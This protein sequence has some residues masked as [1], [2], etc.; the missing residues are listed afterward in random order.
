MAEPGD[1]DSASSGDE[2]PTSDE[3]E[4]E[5]WKDA[6]TD[7]VARGGLR[8]RQWIAEHKRHKSPMNRQ[9][10]HLQTTP[11][12]ALGCAW[13]VGIA[14]AVF[15]KAWES[16]PSAATVR[17]A[18]G[19]SPADTVFDR[20]LDALKMP[21]RGADIPVVKGH[22]QS[23]EREARATP[24]VGELL[25]FRD[26][27]DRRA[28]A[29]AAH[30]WPRPVILYSQICRGLTDAN[31]NPMVQREHLQF[32]QRL[33]QRVGYHVGLLDRAIQHGIL[34]WRIPMRSHNRGHMY[35]MLVHGKYLDT[36][37][38]LHAIVPL[39]GIGAD[40]AEL[41]TFEREATVLLKALEPL[42]PIGN[43]EDHDPSFF[44]D[45][46]AV[47]E[48]AE[49]V[50]PRVLRLI[51]PAL[52]LATVVVMPY[53][54]AYETEARQSY[55]PLVRAR[56]QAASHFAGFRAEE[57]KKVAEAINADERR[58]RLLSRFVY[59]ADGGDG[60]SVPIEPGDAK[61]SVA[62]VSLNTGPSQLFQAERFG[63]GYSMQDEPG[64]VGQVRRFLFTSWATAGQFSRI[65]VRV[66]SNVLEDAKFWAACAGLLQS[67]A[68]GTPVEAATLVTLG[69]SLTQ[70]VVRQL[71]NVNVP[72]DQYGWV[73][74]I[75][76]VSLGSWAHGITLAPG[77]GW[78]MRF[79][80][81]L[82]RRV[83]SWRHIEDLLWFTD[84]F[85]IPG[86]TANLCFSLGWI[87]WVV[88]ESL[89]RHAP[90]ALTPGV[91]AAISVAATGAAYGLASYAAPAMVGGVFLARGAGA[92]WGQILGL[93]VDW[94]TW[95][96][97]RLF[98]F[99]AEQ[100]EAVLRGRPAVRNLPD[101]RTFA[102]R[103]WR[104]IGKGDAM[105]NAARRDAA[106]L[107][108]NMQALRIQ[109]DAD[110]L[111]NVAAAR[112][113]RQI[114]DT[115]PP[116]VGNATRGMGIALDH[117]H[118][119]TEGFV[120]LPLVAPQV[121][122]EAEAATETFMIGLAATAVGSWATNQAMGRFRDRFYSEQAKWWVNLAGT[123]QRWVQHV[124]TLGFSRC[125]RRQS[126]SRLPSADEQKA[127][128]G[129]EAG[130]QYV[131][132]FVNAAQEQVADKKY[133]LEWIREQREDGMDEDDIA[134]LILDTHG[135][136]WHRAFKRGELR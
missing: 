20:T 31:I 29:I 120:V 90:A 109:T 122:V 24:R 123:P 131:N 13:L 110:A 116:E 38:A 61:L 40:A 102:L 21:L 14:G 18:A 106:V 16:L 57:L 3:H 15:S 59:T 58:G 119:Q 12:E 133:L 35:R 91:F 56:E 87:L 98:G 113:A 108:D 68:D 88:V 136:G 92:T 70:C 8:Q 134:A 22:Q 28:A 60:S 42:L 80:G 76:D 11:R 97:R 111:R 49:F 118:R 45:P 65:S 135:E 75:L 37:L 1:T 5:E 125:R 101:L 100:L 117:M 2:S 44:R 25:A 48:V 66:V 124:F 81:C 127:S 50:T 103:C 129:P 43:E 128:Q 23:V 4:V 69:V 89:R 79:A 126:S 17:K 121:E 19:G 26:G 71:R 64:F 77:E 115:L 104:A 95:P 114:L 46:R 7:E 53:V 34:D 6:Q 51:A 54:R 41:T 132:G 130:Y 107:D 32:I 78:I 94:T 105:L 82:V 55:P 36:L 96:V 93:T 112:T 85:L 27:P 47:L 62:I 86:T 52:T 63:N 74:S 83:V 73:R 10:R 84:N 9:R 72:E 99:Y 67:H 33:W 30:A 39:N